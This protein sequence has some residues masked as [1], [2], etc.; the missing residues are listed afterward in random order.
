LASFFPTLSFA[1][2]IIAGECL[3]MDENTERMALRTLVLMR[4]R[5]SVIRAIR[6]GSFFFICD[7]IFYTN[8]TLGHYVTLGRLWNRV[9]DA[10]K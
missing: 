5:R 7:D 4:W 9:V 6:S 2:E 3:V 8:S 1:Y 10:A